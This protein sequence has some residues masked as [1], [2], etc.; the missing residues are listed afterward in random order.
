MKNSPRFIASALIALAIHFFV[1]ASPA[2]AGFLTPDTLDEILSDYDKGS[3]LVKKNLIKRI[4]NLGVGM[5]MINQVLESQGRARVFCPPSEPALTD[6]HY[7]DIV[8]RKVGFYPE[9][10][11]TPENEVATLLLDVLIKMYPCPE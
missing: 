11:A 8:K 1:G 2:N 10:G 5:E 3:I 9:L 4:G 6:G 7:F